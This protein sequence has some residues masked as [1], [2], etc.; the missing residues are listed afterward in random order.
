CS[1]RLLAKEQRGELTV[2]R[3]SSVSSSGSL[4]VPLSAMALPSGP[5]AAPPTLATG[6]PF[7]VNTDHNSRP[8][9]PS[10]ALNSSVLPSSLIDCGSEPAEGWI[11]DSRMV[12]AA[13]P[14]LRQS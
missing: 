6:A 5:L 10:S 3:T 13:V 12:V 2:Q 8:L 11:S 1:C 4:A 9:D 14:A 7:V